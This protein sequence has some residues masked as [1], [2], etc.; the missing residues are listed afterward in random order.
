M[1]AEVIIVAVASDPLYGIV[2][3]VQALNSET[4][5][6]RTVNGV[7]FDPE[8]SYDERATFV[9]EFIRQ[10]NGAIRGTAGG[11]GEQITERRAIE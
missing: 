10:L 8:T 5:S 7:N 9:A 11:S 1:F 4:R 2:I 6:N 3:P